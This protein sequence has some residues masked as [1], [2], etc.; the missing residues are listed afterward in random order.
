ME[1]SNFNQVLEAYKKE[2]EKILEKNLKEHGRV[3]SG[4][5][6]KSITVHSKFTNQDVTV[7]LDAADYL[8]QLSEGRK[9]TNNGGNGQLKDKIKTWIEQKNILPRPDNLGK[10]LTQDQLAFL[11]ARKIHKEGYAGSNDYPMTVDAVNAKYLPLLQKALE[12]D[13][14]GEAAILI[15]T[16]LNK[17]IF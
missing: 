11:I 14:N 3:A 8:L 17:I 7:V 15:N 10:V 13:I 16:T 4:N 12:E 2:F 9:P 5:L 1:L 6:I